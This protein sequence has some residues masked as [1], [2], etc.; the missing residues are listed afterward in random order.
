[1]GRAPGKSGSLAYNTPVRRGNR[2]IET[3]GRNGPVERLRKLVGSVRKAVETFN[4][5]PVTLRGHRGKVLGL[6]EDDF[7]SSAKPNGC[8]EY[9][10][11][12]P[13]DYSRAPNMPEPV[14]RMPNPIQNIKAGRNIW[15][16]HSRRAGICP[17]A[18]GRVSPHDKAPESDLA[19]AVGDF[20]A[21][22]NAGEEP[23]RLQHA[24]RQ[25]M[26]EILRQVQFAARG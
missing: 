22:L 2:I 8:P 17:G 26:G 19:S 16:T 4:G 1:M 14:R 11:P 7:V 5:L 24:D 13:E 15:E 25:Q 18:R 21:D 23:L 6:A 3:E 9:S 10:K 20:A 12:I